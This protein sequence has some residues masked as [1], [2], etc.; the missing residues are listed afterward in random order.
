MGRKP[1]PKLFIGSSS[2][3][4]D[5]VNAFAQVLADSADCIPWFLADEFSS[6]ASFSSFNAL[7]EASQVYDFGLFILTPDDS[8]THRRKKYKCPRDN[9]VF[10]MGLFIGNLGPERVLGVLQTV[11][12]PP[13]KIPS[14]LLSVNMPRF[15]FDNEDRGASIAS[16]HQEICR[17]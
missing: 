2:E 17:D 13:M 16:P 6:R 14:D 11:D 15:T 12:K 3:Q 10:E 9:V 4:K 7:C 1:L 8:L 5:V